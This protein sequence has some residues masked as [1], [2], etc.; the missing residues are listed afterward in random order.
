MAPAFAIRS[1]DAISIPRPVQPIEGDIVLL[2]M[3]SCELT[4][5]TVVSEIV[6]FF[7]Q[8]YP[9]YDIIMDGD[10]YAIV[11]RPKVVG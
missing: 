2:D 10:Q 7:K 4:L 1:A 11:A 9:E 8:Q 6:P 3:R 5:G